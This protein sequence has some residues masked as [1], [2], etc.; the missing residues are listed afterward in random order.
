MISL[1]KQNVSIFFIDNLSYFYRFILLFKNG[2]M[3]SNTIQ[4]TDKYTMIPNCVSYRNI[5]KAI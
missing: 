5:L 2:Q 1:K 3:Y 4:Y